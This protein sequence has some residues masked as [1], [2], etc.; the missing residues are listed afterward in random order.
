MMCG[1]NRNRSAAGFALI[2]MIGVLVVIVLLAVL[3]VPAVFGAIQQ[4]W[5][6]QTLA[7]CH[8]VKTACLQ[9][10][11]RLSQL[12]MDGSVNPPTAIS[13]RSADPKAAQFDKVLLA[14][15]LLDKLFSP[16]IG[17]KLLDATHTRVQVV[18]G[19]SS[20]AGVDKDN[21]A[22]D[23]DGHGANSA[24]GVA[25]VEAVITGV[26]LEDA[27][28]LN[29]IL[30]G[31]AL[32]EDPSGNDFSGRLKYGK[33]NQGNGNGNNGNGKGNQPG[34]TVELHLYLLHR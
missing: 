2:E 21:S 6:D 25:V 22:Y 34:N 27:R 20:R 13:L 33:P 28:V 10:G 8:T 30:D 9:H 32:G 14:E 17:D 12:A 1:R 11:A 29:K 31:N 24:S 19:L 16:K 7:A 15:G 18:A 5:L 3:L 26:S 4:A 23:F